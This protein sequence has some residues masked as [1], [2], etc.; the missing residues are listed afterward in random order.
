[1]ARKKTELK[2]VQHKS[3]RLYFFPLLK[4]LDGAER[5]LRFDLDVPDEC[6][7][8]VKQYL[9]IY[10]ERILFNRRCAPP[11]PTSLEDM[12]YGNLEFW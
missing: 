7:P 3:P 8:M 2:F 1:M 11:P 6:K 5:K 4:I 10:T 12:T 9:D